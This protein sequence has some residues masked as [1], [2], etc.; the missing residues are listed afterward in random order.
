MSLFS[1]RTAVICHDLFMVTLA[2]SV[3]IWLPYNLAD[4]INPQ[5]MQHFAQTLALVLAVQSLLFWYYGLYEGIWRFASLPDLWNILRS[6]GLGVLV[7]SLL[8]VLLNRLEGIPRLGLLVYPPLLLAL[9]SLPRLSYRLLREHSFRF[10]FE[11]RDG[12]RVLLLGAGQAGE[13]LLREMLR[14]RAYVILGI[15]DDDKRLHGGR[16]HGIRVLGGIN[17]LQEFAEKLQIE[18][19]VIAM[20]SSSDAQMQRVVGACESTGIPF[21]TLPKLQDMVGYQTGLDALRDVDID[22]LLGRE[23]V[24]LDW[25]G[26]ESGLTDQVVMVSGGGGSIG[27][28]LCHQIARVKPSELIVLERSE[29]N[30]Y[31]IQ[32]RLQ[33]QFPELTFHSCLAD[34]CDEAAAERLVAQY[35]PHIIFHAA[36][37]KHVPMLQTHVREAVMNNV[38]GTQTMAEA[39]ARHGCKSFVLISTD[40]AVNPNN[41][42]GAT[43]RAAEIY[44][45]TLNERVATNFV[46]VRFGNVLNSS[47]SVI[48]LFQ[49]QIESGGPVTVTHPDTTRY[50]MT[51]REACE[52]ILQAVALGQGG[53]I[54][55]LDMGVPVQIRYLAEQLIHLAGKR[56]GK[57]IEIVYTGLR[58]GEKLHEELFHIEEEQR[59]RTRHEKIILASPRTNEWA[60]IQ[61]CLDA[62]KR[63]CA[64]FDEDALFATLRRLTPEFQPPSPHESLKN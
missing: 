43:K 7:I 16:V 51:L 5:I 21:R 17:H 62:F 25:S 52:L 19:L 28:E 22:D 50:F 18:L 10:V 57:E 60:V 45:Q 1:R 30:L 47:G 54:F 56:P 46:T 58:P 32:M 9:L 49:S 13:M 64:T 15:I 4:T 40:K 12:Q 6:I 59:S 29:Y 61:E 11:S 53:E 36:A 2:W 20:P 35:K 31:H 38:L 37:Y 23:K 34:I 41:V 39:A 8:L 24:Q 27:A 26:I 63:D 3:A 48:P 55:V 42:L 14:T 44:C 33:Q